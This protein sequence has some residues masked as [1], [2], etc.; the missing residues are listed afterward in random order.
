M[1]AVSSAG[2][3]AQS[4]IV[5]AEIWLLEDAKAITYILRTKG[6]GLSCEVACTTDKHR[7]TDMSANLQVQ[8]L[9]HL[10]M[11]SLY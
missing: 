8:G 4:G 7:I 1:V 5:V 6:Q 10:D 9:F 11:F 3:C 2:R